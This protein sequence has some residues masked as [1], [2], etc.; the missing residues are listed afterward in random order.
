MMIRN[1][2]GGTSTKDTMH[3][4]Q[5]IRSKKFRQFDYGTDENMARYG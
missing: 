4:F 3:W 2:V 1:D 5:N